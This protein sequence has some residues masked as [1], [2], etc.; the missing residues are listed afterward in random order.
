MSSIIDV[1]F[2]IIKIVLQMS[3]KHTTYRIHMG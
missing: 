2:Y 3:I 1:T